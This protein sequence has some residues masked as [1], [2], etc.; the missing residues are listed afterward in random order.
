LNTIDK[1]RS[2]DIFHLIFYSVREPI[3]FG[4][5]IYEEVKMK[6]TSSLI[7]IL[8][9][10]LLNTA[11]TSAASG[12]FFEGKKI[13]FIV[14]SSPG[15]GNDTYVRLVARYISKYLPGNPSIIVQNMPGAGGVVA[16]N[17][18]YGKARRDGT[19]WSQINSGAWNYQIIKSKRARF[20][21]NKIN[22]IGFASIENTVMYVRKDR[23]QGLK[24][25]RE[26]GKL[27]R[28]GASGR[29]SSGSVLGSLIEQVL[30]VKLF[31]L[32][33]GYPGARQ[34]SLAVRQGEVDASGNTLASF[35]DQLGDMV[36]A[37]DLIVMVQAGTMEGK[38]DP[39]LPDVPLLS[40]IAE[41]P[42]AKD[43]ANSAFLLAHYTRGFFMPPG[44]PKKR[45]K[46]I[47]DAFW[48]SMKDPKLIQ[49]AKR[50]GRP[51]RPGRGEKLQEMLKTSLSPSP[52]MYKIVKSIYG[53]A[54]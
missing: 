40:E 2:D 44:V 35:L 12:S 47:R 39:R 25:I 22:P 28:V 41:T 11:Q 29:Q 36:K 37:G 53:T 17:Y 20:D 8:S 51:I 34:Y 30:G 24:G 19:V 10:L 45:V 4:E 27:A 32:I 18:L 31:E 38:R 49:E 9:V 5:T 33:L 50:M 14:S 16:A 48:K 42:E 46:L 6:G 52:E 23:F 3:I 13:R 54:K 15:G 1:I 43:L 7:A 26:S 21:F